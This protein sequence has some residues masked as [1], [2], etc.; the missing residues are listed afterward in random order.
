[1]DIINGSAKYILSFFGIF[2]ELFKWKKPREKKK[3][4]ESDIEEKAEPIKHGREKVLYLKI[5]FFY[6][7]EH[8]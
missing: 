7:F 1:M 5:K 6:E 4:A 2:F 8:F 3:L